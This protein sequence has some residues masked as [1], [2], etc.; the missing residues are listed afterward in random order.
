MYTPDLVAEAILHA[1]EHPTRDLLIGDNAPLQSL[2][3][4]LAPK[5]GDK[6]MRFTMFQGQKS[7]RSPKS[8][9]HQA[10]EKASGTLKEQSDYDVAVF[11]L[12]PYTAIAKYPLVKT[13]AAAALGLAAGAIL[14]RKARS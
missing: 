14:F 12:S 11:R 10:L 6:F 9:D 2:M 5:L 4:T 8:G 13:T 7:S 3:G 1:A